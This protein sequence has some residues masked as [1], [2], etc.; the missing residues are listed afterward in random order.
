MCSIGWLYTIQFPTP[1]FLDPCLAL[2]AVFEKGG[3]LYHATSA[4]TESLRSSIGP[5]N[6]VIS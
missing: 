3:G 2:L 6:L 4:V 1:E 5:P